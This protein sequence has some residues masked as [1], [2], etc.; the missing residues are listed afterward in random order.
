MGRVIPKASVTGS[1]PDHTGNINIGGDLTVDGDLS[2]SGVTTTLDT[3]N[4]VITDNLI[5]LNDGE[6]GAG[7]TL[8][9]SGIQIDRGSLTDYQLIFDESDDTFKY[10]EIGSL[11]AFPDSN[12]INYNLSTGLL[13]GGTLSINGD[14]TKFDIAAGKGLVVD[15]YTDVNN[16]SV[17]EVTWTTQTA[18]V[19]TNLATQPVTYISFDSL[20]AVIQR[21]THPTP[22]QH[23]EEIFLGVIV[24]SNNTFINV[25][26]NLPSILISPYSQLQ[27][28]MDGL[29]IFRISGLVTAANGTNLSFTKTSG[30]LLVNGGNYTNNPADPHQVSISGENPVTFRYRTQNSTESA[31]TTF[32][33]PGNYD[34]A[35]T[36]TAIPGSNNRASIHR[37]FMFPSG[38]V[39][40]QY[41]QAWYSSLTEAVQSASVEPFIV[42]PNILDNGILIGLI[43]IRKGATDLSLMTD[44]AFI[45]VSKFGEVASISSQSGGTLQQTY[46]NSV[47]P[48]IILDS[49]RGAV[50][51]QDNSTPI[52]GNLLE[53]QSNGGGTTYFEVDANG[54]STTGNIIVTGTVDGRD[55]AADGITLDALSVSIQ[56]ITATPYAVLAGDNILLIN[57]G[58]N[59]SITLPAIASMTSKTVRIKNS[60]GDAATFNITITPDGAETIDG[61]GSFILD[62]NYVAIDLIPFGTNWSVL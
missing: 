25:I 43:A 57:V 52:A 48:E 21:I 15:A 33:D 9:T 59:T 1:G 44:A 10:G 61:A 49:T 51:I 50:S 28:L 3:D 38:I 17:T 32:A 22:Q 53:V 29:G 6:V 31:N 16:T 36:V 45:S 47:S 41:G 14:N 46:D 42:E 35:G 37:I 2:V 11:T 56:E 19:V 4:L 18:I 60:G 58:A 7:V 12:R 34:V 27:D 23:R 8:G 39:R 26:N 40:V 54:T 13:E 24:H 55:I 20:G 5:V 30:V 62:E